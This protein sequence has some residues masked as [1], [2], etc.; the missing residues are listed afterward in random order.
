VTRQASNRIVVQLPGV[1]DPNE[2]IRV[3]GATATL[4]FRLVDETNNPY[5][6]ESNKRI[7]DR[8]EALQRAQR[9][10]D[11]AEA[12]NHRDLVSS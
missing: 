4:E 11:S 6:A 10:P 1:Q 12:R 7:P 5:E 9:P 2:A 8:L 3:L